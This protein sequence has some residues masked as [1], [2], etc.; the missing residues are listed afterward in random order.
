[1]EG[2]KVQSKEKSKTPQEFAKA[3]QKL[4]E[5]FNYRV[6][7][8]PVWMARDDGSFSLVLQSSVGELEKQ[9]RS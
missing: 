9:Q 3:Y 4:C 8:T 1:M 6:V 2:T 5:E 7:S